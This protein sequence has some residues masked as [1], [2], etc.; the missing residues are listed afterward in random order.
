[1]AM[2]D[3]LS[4]TQF[5][6]SYDGDSEALSEHT[7]DARSVGT[8]LIALGELFDRANLVLNGE[9]ASVELNVQANTSGSFEIEIL[10][11]QAY[12]T[13]APFL[14]GG[15]VTSAA[16]LITIVAGSNGLIN[17][18]KRLRGNSPDSIARDE[19]NN[20]ATLEYE[21]VIADA[22]IRRRVTL[23]G[24]EALRLYEDDQIAKNLTDFVS[25][26]SEDGINQVTF[27]QGDQELESIDEDEAFFFRVHS[28]DV[29]IDE[30]IIPRQELVVIS[31][32]LGLGQNKWRLNDSLTTNW[33]SMRDPQFRNG[34]Q[35]GIVQF[36]VDNVLICEV[37]V[38]TLVRNGKVHRD[39]E[40]T[41]VF[42]H[43]SQGF[44][45]PLFED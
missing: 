15:M 41:K 14:A 26:L 17:L 2:R 21:E 38:T 13:A 28:D 8:A 31:P 33:Y 36:G 1:M 9:R 34:I 44:Q 5:T 20:S 3:D 7:M 6:V 29:E 18:I 24:L 27:K 19:V 39:F 23:R 25:V 10:L 12:I 37:K 40:I 42:E 35:N 30:F 16:N 45:P 22:A 4:S 11:A 43:Q 32:Y